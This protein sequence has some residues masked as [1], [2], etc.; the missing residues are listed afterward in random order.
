MLLKTPGLSYIDASTGKKYPLSVLRL[1]A[2]VL[3]A[4]QPAPGP[5]CRSRYHLLLDGF[6]VEEEARGIK[7]TFAAKEK[8]HRIAACKAV[9]HALNGLP[10]GGTLCFYLSLLYHIHKVKSNLFTWGPPSD[11]WVFLSVPSLFVLL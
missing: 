4:G 3:S 8:G 5:V 6:F 9:S 2:W 7:R 10:I 11:Y 1:F